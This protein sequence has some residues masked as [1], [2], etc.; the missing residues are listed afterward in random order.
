M[1]DYEKEVICLKKNGK[2]Q[3][4]DNQID[5]NALDKKKYEAYLI[6]VGLFSSVF[7]AIEPDSKWIRPIKRIHIVYTLDRLME[8]SFDYYS[9]DETSDCTISEYDTKTIEFTDVIDFIFFV[10]SLEK[11]ASFNVMSN[12]GFGHATY[13]AGFHMEYTPL[14]GN[15]VQFEVPRKMIDKDKMFGYGFSV[16]TLVKALMQFFDDDDQKF[17]NPK[18]FGRQY[19][20]IAPDLKSWNYKSHSDEDLVTVPM[21]QIGCCTLINT[22]FYTILDTLKYKGRIDIQTYTCFEDE[23]NLPFGPLTADV[24][25]YYVTQYFELYDN[26]S[27][28]IIT[29]ADTVE[30][31]VMMPYYIKTVRDLGS[32]SKDEMTVIL[33]EERNILAQ[34]KIYQSNDDVIPLKHIIYEKELEELGTD[35]AVSMFVKTFILWVNKP[36]LIDGIVEDDIIPF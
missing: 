8:G 13:L 10:V 25:S 5:L 22:S 16:P 15:T 28:N 14:N 24:I 33:S 29:A 31:A 6:Q 2:I 12:G 4:V 11:I 35:E 36:E 19:A 27:Y 30:M 21:V 18:F 17:T 20:Y 3:R 9:D 26:Y 32:L 23:D 1:I 34:M 7:K